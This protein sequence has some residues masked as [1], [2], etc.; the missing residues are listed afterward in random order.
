MHNVRTSLQ[1]VQI[2]HVQA[3]AVPCTGNE[4]F[5]VVERPSGGPKENFWEVSS[6]FDL[7]EHCISERSEIVLTC[8]IF[9]TK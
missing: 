8:P 9:C 3:F 6:T 4:P 7:R 1:F 2:Y 5:V